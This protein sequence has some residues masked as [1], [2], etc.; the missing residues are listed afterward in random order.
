LF[1]CRDERFLRE[2]FALAQAARA[3]ISERTDQRLIARHDA[4]AGFAVAG[5]TA[6]HQ[7][8]VTQFRGFHFFHHVAM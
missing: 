4:T 8:G 7:I 3:A 2:I 5:Q 6:G 1:P